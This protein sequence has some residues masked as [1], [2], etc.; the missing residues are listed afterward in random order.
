MWTCLWTSIGGWK[1]NMWTCP[2]VHCAT[3]VS[4]IVAS[5]ATLSFWV[6]DLNGSAGAALFTLVRVLQEKETVSQQHLNQIWCFTSEQMD[7]WSVAFTSLLSTEPSQ[8]SPTTWGRPSLLLLLLLMVGMSLSKNGL[9]S[10][11]WC[12][13]KWITWAGVRQAYSSLSVI[14]PGAEYSFQTCIP[15][16]I[17]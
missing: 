17:M 10:V 9:S 16:Y 11:A 5:M 4:Y 15:P 14:M 1:T 12:R 6:M 8:L 3:G 2:T 13:I 7:P